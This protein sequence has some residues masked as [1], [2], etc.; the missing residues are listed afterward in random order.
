MH[1]TH[2]KI[3]NLWFFRAR[4]NMRQKL[5]FMFPCVHEFRWTFFSNFLLFISTSG[6]EGEQLAIKNFK[7][8]AKAETVNAK[9]EAATAKANAKF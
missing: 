2:T 4:Q 1:E 6:S 8:N 7:A 5:L 9:V 3:G